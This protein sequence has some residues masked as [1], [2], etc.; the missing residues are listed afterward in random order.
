MT[1]AG[2]MKKRPGLKAIFLKAN[3]QISALSRM[4]QK[5]YAYVTPQNKQQV[6]VITNMLTRKVTFKQAIHITQM[7]NKSNKIDEHL[8]PD[9]TINSSIIFGST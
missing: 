9:N 7:H 8:L 4:L 1:N 2:A 3:F 6:S 5:V